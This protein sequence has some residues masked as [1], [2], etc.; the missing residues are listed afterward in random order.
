MTV[1]GRPGD[2]AVGTSIH[3]PRPSSA[4]H[5]PQAGKACT[6]MT[7]CGSLSPLC[8]QRRTTRGWRRDAGAPGWCQPEGHCN[9]G[10]CRF[11]SLVHLHYRNY[12]FTLGVAGR[13]RLRLDWSDQGSA[14]LGGVVLP[15]VASVQVCTPKS[16]WGDKQTPGQ[17][18][19]EGSRATHNPL[20]SWSDLNKMTD[21]AVVSSKAASH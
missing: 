9:P 17:C 14:P 12:P 1:R 21:A 8:S 18:C 10:T 2:P 19:Q 7:I 20:C 6:S 11:L 4:N 3:C 13:W 15:L 16:H 5:W